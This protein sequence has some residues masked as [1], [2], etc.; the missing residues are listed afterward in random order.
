MMAQTALDLLAM[1]IRDKLAEVVFMPG[2]AHEIAA[3]Q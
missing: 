2:N 1:R 3:K